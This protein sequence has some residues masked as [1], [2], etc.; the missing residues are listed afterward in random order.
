M[1]ELKL[2]ATMDCRRVPGNGTQFPE[3]HPPG[4]R[5]G[6]VNTSPKKRH[7]QTKYRVIG[8]TQTSTTSTNIATSLLFGM[9]EQFAQSMEYRY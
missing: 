6:C 2:T 3:S 8:R 4:S 1:A 7:N 5:M 9:R